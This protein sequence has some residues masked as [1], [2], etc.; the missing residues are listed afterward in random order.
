MPDEVYYE[1][2]GVSADSLKLLQDMGYTMVQQT[3]WGAAELIMVG[4]PGAPGVTADDSG[5]DSA[6]SGRVRE[7]FLYGSNDV[8]RPA[9][10]AIGY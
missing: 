8:R 10:A 3:P 7:G 6:V 1:Q 9:G 4:L 5:N 2:R